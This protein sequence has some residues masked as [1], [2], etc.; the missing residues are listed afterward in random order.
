MEA[1]AMVGL[2]IDTAISPSHIEYKKFGEEGRVYQEEVRHDGGL[3]Q[4]KRLIA[5]PDVHNENA[6][7]ED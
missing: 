6:L 7:R 4:T 2:A 1:G 3:E 5:V